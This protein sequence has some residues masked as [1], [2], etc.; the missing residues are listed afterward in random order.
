MSK[1]ELREIKSVLREL[2]H[3][4]VESVPVAGLIARSSIVYKW[5]APH[6]CLLIRESVFWR[7]HDLLEQ[8]VL[9][10]EVS[11][12]L[13]A[14]ILLRSSFETL[15]ILIY[16]NEHILKV[17]NNE[18]NYHEFSNKSSTILLGSRDGSTNHSSI[19]IITILDKCDRLYP[20]IKEMYAGL[21]ESA[22]PNYEGLCKGYSQINH[23]EYETNFRNLWAENYEQVHLG[24]VRLCIETF[25]YEYDDLWPK[26]MKELEK[27][28]VQNDDFLEATKPQN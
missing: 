14:R 23:D 7:L 27:W 13:G 6:R 25:L 1:I 20:G 16:L 26:R 8:S 18:L 2:S 15:A 10:Y 3:S 5:K 17:V 22:H 19:N 12:T 4:R 11:K 21:S 24:A 9:L 28:L